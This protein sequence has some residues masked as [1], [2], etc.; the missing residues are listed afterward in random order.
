MPVER[1]KSKRVNVRAGVYACTVPE[2]LRVGAIVD[3]SMEGL[4]FKYIKGDKRFRPID[5]V[6][7]IEIFDEAGRFHL[8]G[9]QFKPSYTAPYGKPDSLVS[10]F[11]R[12]LGGRFE[13]LSPDQGKHLRH[14]I[15][16]FAVS[17]DSRR[18]ARK[19][20]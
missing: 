7:T 19:G 4:S 18:L 14:F 12:R 2:F 1:R 6:A 11:M 9:I 20:V 3:I 5:E 16:E 15:T 17:G 10:S 13:N 8:Q